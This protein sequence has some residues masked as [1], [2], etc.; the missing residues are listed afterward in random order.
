MVKNFIIGILVAAVLWLLYL[1]LDASPAEPVRVAR[2][3][4]VPT[5]APASPDQPLPALPYAPLE[6]ITVQGQVELVNAGGMLV[7]IDP[8]LKLPDG[9]TIIMLDSRP[10][11]YAAARDFRVHVGDRMEMT[12]WH[13]GQGYETGKLTNLTSGE[14]VLLRDENGIPQ[15][16]GWSNP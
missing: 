2:P 9:A 7:K 13:D 1:R 14:S 16:A 5:S 6:W 3:S 12:L 8:N 15:W 4:P 11:V 10:W